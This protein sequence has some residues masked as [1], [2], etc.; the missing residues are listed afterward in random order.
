MM[1]NHPTNNIN[2]I[3]LQ[4][5]PAK[6]FQESQISGTQG[7]ANGVSQMNSAKKMMGQVKGKAHQLEQNNA[8]FGSAQQREE[9]LG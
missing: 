4:T 1:P 9:A 6:F 8:S 2:S 3:V 7:G 5:S